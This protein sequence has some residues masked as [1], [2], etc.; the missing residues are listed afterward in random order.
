MQSSSQYF[1]VWITDAK[2]ILSREVFFTFFGHFVICFEPISYTVRINNSQVNI[3]KYSI[4]FLESIYK[5]Y[6][7]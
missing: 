1:V 7:Q 3:V 4:N 2:T 6:L 5:A